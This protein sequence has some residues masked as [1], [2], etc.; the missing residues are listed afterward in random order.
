MAVINKNIYLYGDWKNKMIIL[1]KYI[2][3]AVFEI[4]ISIT[5]QKNVCDDDSIWWNHECHLATLPSI[6]AMMLAM[7]KVCFFTFA[8][9]ATFYF[10]IL[11][12]YY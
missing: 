11:L 8:I 3:Y 10:I 1:R 7:A 9:V 4:I 5:F 2:L 6:M 12:F